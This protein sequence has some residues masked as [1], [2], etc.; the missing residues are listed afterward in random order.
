MASPLADFLI[1]GLEGAKKERDANAKLNRDLQLAV[2]KAQFAQLDAG[3][4][5]D[6]VQLLEVVKQIKAAA[7]QTT[8]PAQQQPVPQQ[9]PRP[10]IQQQPQIAQPTPQNIQAPQS[11]I[12]RPQ[13]INLP[14]QSLAGSQDIGPQQS[15]A[16]LQRPVISEDLPPQ[17]INV[18]KRDPK[19]GGVFVEKVENPEYKAAID[20]QKKWQGEILKNRKTAM[21]SFSAVGALLQNTVAVWKAAA[22]EKTSRNIP[23][24]LP[25]RAAG[26]VA[27]GL[28]L[29]GFSQTKAYEGQVIETSMAM[30]KI[31]TGGSRIIKSVINQL[32]KTLPKD[33]ARIEDMQAL[34]SQSYR[35]SFARALGRP[36]TRNE[37]KFINRGLARILKAPA[38]TIPTLDGPDSNIAVKGPVGGRNLVMQIDGVNHTFEKMEDFLKFI[39]DPKNR[40]TD[41]TLMFEVTDQK[42]SP[43]QQVVPGIGE[44]FQGQKVIAVERVE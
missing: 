28:D 33:N 14:Q 10:Q 26:G 29:P 5:L 32:A 8:Q 17:F 7:N 13:G 9:Q 27:K 43:Q 40:V 18:T 11:L 21:E 6:Q 37:Q 2:Q 22:A 25:A 3:E 4:I 38:A 16:N 1:G 12:Q 23:A 42:G 15:L 41:K 20:V 19:F 35:N 39:N 30:S 34:I 44:T 24:G 31:I 36:I